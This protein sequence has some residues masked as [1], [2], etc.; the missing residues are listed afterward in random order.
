MKGKLRN[1][2]DRSRQDNL[3]VDGIPEYEEQSWNDTEELIKDALR[4]KL[5]KTRYK[6]KE[7]IELEEKKQVKTE[8]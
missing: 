7:P 6:M 3:R 4:E 5:G 1:L 8:L 2:E